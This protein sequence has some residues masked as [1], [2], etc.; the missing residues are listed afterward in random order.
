MT[1]QQIKTGFNRLAILGAVAV[2]ILVLASVIMVLTKPVSGTRV[3]N[4]MTGE[5]GV[6]TGTHF[7]PDRFIRLNRLGG[8]SRQVAILFLAPVA[9][10][11]SYGA[12]RSLGW[13]IYGF[14]KEEEKE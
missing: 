7:A 6:W 12:I 4:K 10:V 5:T 13:V 2:G 1:R 9:A 14:L 8:K 3:R 11:I